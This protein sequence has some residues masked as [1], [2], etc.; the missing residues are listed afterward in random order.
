MENLA[1]ESPLLLKAEA[2]TAEEIIA[3]MSAEE[4]SELEYR[5]SVRDNSFIIR[6]I[7]YQHYLERLNLWGHTPEE[8]GFLFYEGFYVGH[9]H[10]IFL[11]FGTDFGIPVMLL[12][13]TIVVVGLIKLWKGFVASTQIKDISY[14]L[15]LIVPIGFGMLEYS[16]GVGSIGTLLLFITIGK[17]IWDEAE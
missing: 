9:A 5:E 4:L 17:V 3:Q 14:L 7:I 1:K 11:Q 16:W 12:L 10:N 15:F 8:Q 13:I 2:S 6:K